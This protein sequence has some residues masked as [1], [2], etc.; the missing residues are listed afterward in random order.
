[1]LLTHDDTSNNGAPKFIN[2]IWYSYIYLNY[3]FFMEK[4]TNEWI[5]IRE[6]IIE[7]MNE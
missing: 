4:L 2:I 6:W 1:M 7:K 5:N 3:I